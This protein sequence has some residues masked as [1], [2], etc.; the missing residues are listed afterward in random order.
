MSKKH[1]SVGQK[2]N[3]LD[4]L[5]A[6][7]NLKQAPAPQ[8][9]N[10]PT[11]SEDLQ[12]TTDLKS[13][14]DNPSNEELDNKTYTGEGLPTLFR[15]EETDNLYKSIEVGDKE[16]ASVLRNEIVKVK[17]STLKSFIIIT[18]AILAIFTSLVTYFHVDLKSYIKDTKT[19]IQNNIDE[20]TVETFELKTKLEKVQISQDSLSKNIKQ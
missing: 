5:K 16:T 11:T 19:E 8:Y 1:K 15:K 6:L 10:T 7:E 9:D 3:V 4:A 2:L 18:I 17:S 20:L 14:Q 13:V 12:N